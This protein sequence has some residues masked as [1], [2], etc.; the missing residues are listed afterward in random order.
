MGKNL[1]TGVVHYGEPFEDANASSQKT[2]CLPPAQYEFVITDDWSDGICCEHGVGFTRS[3]TTRTSSLPEESS[4]TPR[5][6]TSDPAPAP[7]ERGGAPRPNP[8]LNQESWGQHWSFVKVRPKVSGQN[9][10]NRTV[11]RFPRERESH[12][13]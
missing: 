11:S 3:L 2:L 8:S 7:N 6:R 5:R 13:C 4:A 12:I 10:G 1:C 9:C